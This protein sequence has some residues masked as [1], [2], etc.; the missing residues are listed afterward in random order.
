MASKR[1]AA[2]KDDDD[3][4]P[5][6]FQPRNAPKRRRLEDDNRTDGKESKET[7][8]VPKQTKPPGQPTQAQREGLSDLPDH[9][10]RLI[11]YRHIL[12]L[13]ENQTWKP[14][15]VR[16]IEQ[17]ARGAVLICMCCLFC[18]DRNNPNDSGYRTEGIH[19]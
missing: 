19:Q 3:D 5:P 8:V 13:L 2:E 16:I 17:H 18:M 9:L 14:A 12:Q 15:L 6:L 4:T 1:K 10:R 7:K 11:E